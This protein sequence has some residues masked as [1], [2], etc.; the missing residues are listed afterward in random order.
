MTVIVKYLSE[1]D[2]SLCA[3]FNQTNSQ[4]PD[5]ESLTLVGML[6]VV[7]N[8]TYYCAFITCLAVIMSMVKL[9]IV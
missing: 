8:L 4:L 9:C 3:I 6:Q 1:K 7:K 2:G 5:V